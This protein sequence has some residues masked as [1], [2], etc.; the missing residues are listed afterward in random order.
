MFEKVNSYKDLIVWQK[1][2]ALVVGV[3]KLTYLFPTDELYGLTSQMRRAAVS[4]PANIAEGR[5]RLSR[6]DFVHF[7]NIAYASG[8]ELETLILIAKDLS[9]LDIKTQAVISVD[10][11][12]NEIMKILNKMINSLKS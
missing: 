3:Y 2:M 1:S 5:R 11:L 7:L 6:K 8:A 12:L 4:L 9:F 10:L